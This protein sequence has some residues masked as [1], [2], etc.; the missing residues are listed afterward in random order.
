MEGPG[1]RF[2]CFEEEKEHVERRIDAD[3]GKEEKPKLHG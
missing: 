1:G 2:S 3:S